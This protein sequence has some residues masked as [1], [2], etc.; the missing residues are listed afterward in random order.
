MNFYSLDGSK[1]DNDLFNNKQIYEKFDNLASQQNNQNE[2]FAGVPTTQSNATDS[3][4]QCSDNYAV[5]GTTFGNVINNSTLQACKT[6][7][8]NSNSNCIG[9]NFNTSNNT[10]TLKQN[11][12]SLMN[13]APSNTL[14]IKKSAG[15][16]NCKV[17]KKI[18][19][20][21]AFNEL[22][23]IFAND[24]EQVKQKIEMAMSNPSH[25]QLED[26][27]KNFYNMSSS[28][29]NLL[30]SN[31]SKA[32]EVP[33]ETIIQNIPKLIKFVNTEDTPNYNVIAAIKQLGLIQQHTNPEQKI[34]TSPS[35]L[36]IPTE[37]EISLTSMISQFSKLNPS[38]QTQLIN[39][40][41]NYSGVTPEYVMKN[42]KLL[43]EAIVTDQ[44]GTSGIYNKIQSLNGGLSEQKNI[45]TYPMIVPK[46]EKLMSEMETMSESEMNS[47]DKLAKMKHEQDGIFVDLDC[48]MNNI[49]T[50]KNH[51]DGMMIDL[52]LLL[53]NVKSC[54][55]VKKTKLHKNYK[56]DKNDNKDKK[57]N[58]DSQTPE[59]IVNKITSNIEMPTPDIVKLQSM[60]S[61]ITV[62]SADLTSHGQVLG[63]VKEPFDTESYYK[64][65]DWDS[66]DFIKIVILVIILALLIFRK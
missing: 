1:T 13:S 7:C 32:T 62:P 31:L 63:I 50:L 66:N 36:P 15:N 49:Q 40:L 22:N 38:Q 45:S 56:N 21:S 3:N 43:S 26:M 65:N 17:S 16:K 37:S 53:S 41:S 27:I 23:A 12:T 55:Y 54:S 47:S 19:N 51:S 4:Y 33:S 46:V 34:F 20:E 18:Q 44:I 48:F 29:Q 2:L 5:S 28:E 30:L 42:M 11:A 52:S 6:E 61:T 59:Q 25:K 8:A 14:C 9:F 58:L 39:T 10:C 60:K 64:K 35:Q 57:N 24:P